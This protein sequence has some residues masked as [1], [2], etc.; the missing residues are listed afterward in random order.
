MP[1]LV[2]MCQ[3]YFGHKVKQHMAGLRSQREINIHWQNVGAPGYIHGAQAKYPKLFGHGLF[4]FFT[5]TEGLM[6]CRFGFKGVK[7]ASR[8]RIAPKGQAPQQ[9][10]F[11][12]MLC[13]MPKRFV[14]L[15]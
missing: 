6:V 3:R 8:N 4:G 14:V 1:R 13:R 10:P 5:V 9:F 15:R 2:V 7:K 11:R 12:P